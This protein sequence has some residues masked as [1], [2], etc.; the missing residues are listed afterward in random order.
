[1]AQRARSATLIPAMTKSMPAIS[2]ADGYSASSSVPAIAVMTGFSGRN[3]VARAAPSNC[4][5]FV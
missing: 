5:V 1:M 4:T 3:R 2:I